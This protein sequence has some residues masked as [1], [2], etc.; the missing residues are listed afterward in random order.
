MMTSKPRAGSSSGG[1]ERVRSLDRQITA[2]D[3][4]CLRE[5]FALFGAEREEAITTEE[6]GRVMSRFG[7]NMKSSE[8]LDMMKEAD[9]AGDGK[10]DYRSKSPQVTLMQLQSHYACQP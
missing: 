3:L 5:A 2:L 9:C 1:G 8:L 6:L 4:D 7:E 10:V